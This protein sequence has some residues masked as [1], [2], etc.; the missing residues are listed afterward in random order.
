MKDD[1]KDEEFH[2]MME[3]R[4]SLRRVHEERRDTPDERPEYFDFRMF[5]ER[6]RQRRRDTDQKH[7][8]A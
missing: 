2:R 1:K 8:N 7:G 6:R 3:R 5:M 4:K